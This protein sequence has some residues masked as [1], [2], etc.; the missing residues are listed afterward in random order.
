MRKLILICHQDHFISGS[1]R[2]VIDLFKS[3][4]SVEVCAYDFGINYVKTLVN[5]Y[6]D[7]VFVLW[8]TEPMAAWLT[9][10]GC[11]V[12]AFPMYDGCEHAPDSY[13]R[14]LD[15]SYL[16]NFSEALH[17]KS[18]K[19]GVVSYRLKFYPEKAPDS[20]EKD[21]KLFFW[22]RRPDSSISEQ[23]I[24]QLF[25]PYV[26]SIHIHDRQ[27]GYQF[28]QNT[29]VNSDGYVST[30]SWFENK[31]DLVGLMQQSKY[32]I[33]PRES[34]GIGMGF[35]EAMA[36]GTIV[37]A[38]NNSTHNEYIYDG[39]NGFLIDFDTGDKKL[40]RKQIQNAFKKINSGATI[41]E[42]A[43]KF[44]TDG[45]V[46]WQESRQ[47]LLE[48]ACVIHDSH[49]QVIAPKLQQI[50]GYLILLMFYKSPKLY[51][52]LTLVVEKL[53]FFVPTKKRSTSIFHFIFQG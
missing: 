9:S 39:Y 23:N 20:I 17:K 13:F 5:T 11:K 25:S 6:P 43:K 10:L 12:L 40:I 50:I 14:L 1:N 18:T 34:E 15:N 35:L 21:D 42:N 3:E 45:T 36:S 16:F 8:Q 26:G 48:I 28:S 46:S 27:D 51:A 38:N 37:F 44:I 2:F 32:Y 30:S 33:A 41:G 31:N 22:L 49:N 47:K 53:H 24:K 7:A 52:V 19:A 29:S 4:F